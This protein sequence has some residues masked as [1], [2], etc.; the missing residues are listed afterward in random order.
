LESS[1][2][3]LW[4]SSRAKQPGEGSLKHRTST[5]SSPVPSTFRSPARYPRRCCGSPSGKE[6]ARISANTAT[7]FA[8][9]QELITN[10]AVV[11]AATRLYY[12]PT[13]GRLKRAG[14]VGAPGTVRR[15]AEVLMQLD[16]VWDLYQMSPEELIAMLPPEF[17]RFRR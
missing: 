9:R 16:V 12:D 14:T 11:A 6:S 4:R 13:K 10:P 1:S 3:T 8:A 2:I 5:P 17:D 7:S 15:F